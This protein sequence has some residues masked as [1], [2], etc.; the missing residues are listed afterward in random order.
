MNAPVVEIAGLEKH[1]GHFHALAGIDLSVPAGELLALL[2]H[3]GAGKTTLMKI[4]LGLTGPSA[5]SVHVLGTVPG[6]AA[7]VAQRSRIGF[8]PENVVFAG[9]M[10]GR[11]V[12]RW[13]ARLKRRAAGEVGPLLERVGLDDAA[14]KRVR[15]YSKGMR[16]RLGLAQA[17]LGEPR[18]LLLDEPTTGLD[19]V[20]RQSFYAIVG[21]L[22]RAGTTVIVSSHVLTELEMR[23]DRIAIMSGGRL[24]ASNT[25]P[26]LCRQAGLP[27]RIRVDIDP[28]RID[29]AVE[30]SGGH[31]LADH[32]GG[33][34]I[35]VR[36]EDKLDAV[37][38]LTRL[39]DG[40]VRDLQIHP[41]SL[42]AVYAHYSAGEGARQ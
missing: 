35:A 32:A 41:P 16:Q 22:Q 9:A 39:E 24:L 11:E 5:G 6:R 8:L 19:P 29:D 33:I 4:L 38:G 40:L 27:V 15:T 25:L 3:N 10:T 23:T 28:A 34:D 2:G 12:L 21:E 13:F 1:Y 14:D 7:A 26:E 31:L 18:L 20:L 36:V 42:E 17:L 30:A 37:R